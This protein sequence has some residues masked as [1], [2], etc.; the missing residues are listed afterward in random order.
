MT[1]TDEQLERYSRQ[2]TLPE[3][4]INGQE[5]LANGKVLIIGAGGLGSPAAMYLAAAGIGTIGI[6][7]PDTVELSNLQRQIIHTSRS[8]GMPKTESAKKT[9][10]GINPEANVICHQTRVSSSNISEIINEIN[11]DFI[12]DATDNYTSKFLINDTCVNLRKPFSHGGILGLSGQ[13]MTYI[14]GKGPCYRYVFGSPPPDI[15]P[16]ENEGGVLGI[17]PGIIGT[18]QAAEAIKYLLGMETLVGFILSYDAI[19][20]EFRKI[21]IGCNK[22]CPVCG[23]N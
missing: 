19:K 12:I 9:I 10:A 23:N 4:G 3:I 7:D 6:A 20:T 1:F 8:L 16:E 21:K 2:I 17:V 22:K 14:P 15:N 11:Y 18:L 13:L 5:R